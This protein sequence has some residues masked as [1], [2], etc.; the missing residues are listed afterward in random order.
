MKQATIRKCVSLVLALTLVMALSVTVFA[1]EAED[2]YALEGYEYYDE[3]YGY[4]EEYYE[5]YYE[6]DPVVLPTPA[7]LP[8]PLQPGDFC[9]VTGNWYHGIPTPWAI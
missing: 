6:E 5:Y 3:Y 1:D 7:A 4:D 8:A 2:D 9:Y